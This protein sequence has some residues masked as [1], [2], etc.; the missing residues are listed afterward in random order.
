MPG[1][2]SIAAGSRP[3][4]DTMRLDAAVERDGVLLGLLRGV[5][6]VGDARTKILARA[7]R[8][9]LR[10]HRIALDRTR[11]VQ[12]PL[13]REHSRRVWFSVCSFAG[14]KYRPLALSRMKASS[15]QLSHKSEDD[16]DEFLAHGD[17]AARAPYARRGRNYTPPARSR[18]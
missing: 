8:T 17:S 6:Q 13:H 14:S 5:D 11:D 1:I 4:A 12:R 9:G 3:A 18:T 2:T 10:D 7:R 15:S 16:I